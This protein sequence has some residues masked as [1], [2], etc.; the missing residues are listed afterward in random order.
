MVLGVQNQLRSS[1][2]QEPKEEDI[3]TALNTALQRITEGSPPPTEQEKLNRLKK[4]LA[5]KG[6]KPLDEWLKTEQTKLEINNSLHKAPDI[7]ILTASKLALKDNA[8]ATE[9]LKNDG[10]SR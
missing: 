5:L 6:T 1:S 10:K 8:E 3:M 2:D 7:K 9:I 4:E